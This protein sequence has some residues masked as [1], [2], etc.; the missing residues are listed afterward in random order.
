MLG[1][2]QKIPYTG[3]SSL[4]NTVSIIQHT[5]QTGVILFIQSYFTIGCSEVLILVLKID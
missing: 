1:P 4:E 5:G 2:P 3:Q